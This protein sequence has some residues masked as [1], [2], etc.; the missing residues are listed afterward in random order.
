MILDRKYLNPIQN[1][2]HDEVFFQKK[3]INVLLVGVGLV[4]TELVEQIKKLD[5]INIIGIANSRKFIYNEMGIE[6]DKKRVA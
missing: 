5:N 4:G 1:L 2:V 6:L 3:S